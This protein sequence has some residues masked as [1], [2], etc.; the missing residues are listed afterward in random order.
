VSREETRQAIF[1]LAK[2]KPKPLEADGWPGGIY[3]RSLS[4]DDQLALYESEDKRLVPVRILIEALCDEDGEP[5]FT[6]DDLPALRK[7]PFPRL[8]AAFGRAA[9]ENGLS[10]AELEEAVASFTQAPDASSSSE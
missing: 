7:L 9:K 10:D 6:E 1:D 3:V 2:S 5:L 8:I 4:F